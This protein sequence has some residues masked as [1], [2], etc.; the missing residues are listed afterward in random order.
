MAKFVLIYVDG[1]WGEVEDAM[2][3]GAVLRRRGHEVLMLPVDSEKAEATQAFEGDLR[4]LHGSVVLT[5]VRRFLIPR[6]ESYTLLM[7]S[8]ML[9]DF[10]HPAAA[11]WDGIIVNSRRVFR[12]RLGDIPQLL[13]PFPV[14]MEFY[15]PREPTAE[16]LC[17][18]LHIGT[19]SKPISTINLY[20]GPA[21]RFDLHIHGQG[22]S[23][24]TYKYEHASC[25]HEVVDRAHR[26]LYGPFHR[27][28]IERALM[29]V[30]Y[31][32][33]KINI[34]FHEPDNFADDQPNNRL[35]HSLACRCFTI[36]DR[37]PWHME[38]FWDCAAFTAGGEDT[39][40]LIEE[41]LAHPEKGKA[42]A[43]RGRARILEL[44]YD[45]DTFSQDLE[46]FSVDFRTRG[47]GRA[48]W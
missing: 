37:L 43:E 2:G 17:D 8:P 38:E 9:D 32:S 36:E 18:V 5:S 42:M 47:R 6:S 20:L 10:S 19:V 1:Y 28:F 34:S 27:G 7:W 30:A 24:G 14:D 23:T 31:S 33:C 16:L 44:G 48:G 41:Y 4:P 12:D 11:E 21:T 15:Q 3:L 46:A 35:L 45:A 40:R 39:E 29:P 13:R 25:T 26:N 22:W